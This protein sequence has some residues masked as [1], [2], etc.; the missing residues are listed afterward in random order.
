MTAS[1]FDVDGTLVN[2]NLMHTAVWYMANDI[3]PL[4]SA[5][6]LAGLLA[7]AP[8]LVWAELR[9]RRSFNEMLFEAF[10]GTSEDRLLVLAE[11]AYGWCMKDRI[12][13]GA[14][15]IVRRSKELG[16]EV[17]IV[18]G[19]LDFLLVR[20]AADLGADR[21]LGNRL[22]IHDGYATGKLLRPVVAGPTKARLIADDARDHGH[23]LADCFG[24]SDSYSDVPMLSV[25]GRPAVINPDAKLLRLAH[26]YQWPI[27]E[28]VSSGREA[29]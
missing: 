16:H 3:N 7:R 9:D 26:A 10:R 5:R 25:V 23:E 6:N 11:E 28:L 20:L 2:S 29:R 14:R 27:I 21:V 19:A 17:V 24:Y 8:K 1:Y 13:P 18:S 12:Y 15:D 22:E 4:R